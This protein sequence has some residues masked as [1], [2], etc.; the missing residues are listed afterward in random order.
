MNVRTLCL[1]ILHEREASGYEIRK[2]CTEGECA[3][4]VDASYGSIYP[5]LSRLEDEGLVTSRVEHQDGKPSKKMYAITELGRTA[6]VEALHEPLGEE[7]Y[8]SPFLL[9]VRFAHLLPADLV[10][11]RIREQLA[12]LDTKLEE[13]AKVKAELDADPQGSHANDAWLLRFGQTCL[14]VARDELNAHMH[15]LIATARSSDAHASAA[16]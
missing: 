16:E 6:F 3:Y 9:F 15:E 5:A 13:L 10:E 4:F 12:R 8:R 7:M 11:S 1:S 14:S 2:M